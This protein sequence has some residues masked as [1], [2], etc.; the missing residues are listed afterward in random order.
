MGERRPALTI[1]RL[2]LFADDEQ[3]GEAVLGR[4]RRCEFAKMAASLEP[5]GLPR[6][7]PL[8]RGRYVPAVKAFFEMQ[9][10]IADVTLKAQRGSQRR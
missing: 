6:M 2:P 5:A 10:R 9:H 3:I 1:D 7:N 4:D 8:Y